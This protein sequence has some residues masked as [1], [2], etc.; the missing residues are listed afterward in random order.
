MR[1]RCLLCHVRVVA[2]A[3]YALLLSNDLRLSRVAVLCNNAAV[4]CVDKNFCGL[5]LLLLIAPCGDLVYVD[6]RVRVNR[7]YTKRKRIDTGTCLR[8]L[9]TPCRNIT[10]IIVIQ[11]QRLQTSR[12][13]RQISRLIDPAEI[14]IEVRLVAQITCSM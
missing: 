3:K 2:A 14:V 10:N 7:S 9:R 11:L 4:V 6:D 12:D 8:I 13:T 5:S 1:I